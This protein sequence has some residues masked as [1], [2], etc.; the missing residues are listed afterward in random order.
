VCSTGPWS[1]HFSA[2]FTGSIGP[3]FV[4]VRSTEPVFQPDSRACN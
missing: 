4:S 3:R 2:P 1:A